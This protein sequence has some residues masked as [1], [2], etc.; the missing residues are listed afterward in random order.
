MKITDLKLKRYSCPYDRP[1]SNAKYTYTHLNLVVTTIET[2]D[3]VSGIG[4][5]EG[6]EIVADTL[7]QLREYV[8]GED[9]FAVERI[10]EKMYLPKIFGRK[11]L[12]TRAISC[13]DIALWDLIGKATG[14]PL[15]KLVGGFRDKVP[16]YI[17]GGYFEGDRGID[18]LVDEMTQ[19]VARGATALKMKIGRVSIRQDVERVRAVREAVGDDILLLVDANNAYKPYEAIQI[20][21]H[22]E[23]LGVY[24]FEEPVAPDDL[25]GSAEVARALDI[26]IAAGENE[27]TRYG[28]R[29][30]IEAEAVDIIN[31]D[32]QILGGITEWRKVAS[33]AAA[34]HIPV[35]PHGHQ[36]IHVHLV[37]GAANG[38]IVEYY[39]ENVNPILTRMFTQ[40]LQLENGAVRPPSG[41]G[42][43]VELKEDALERYRVA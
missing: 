1:I 2:T 20:G 43:G 18:G 42:I 27:Y 5:V 33:L 9:P 7:L 28:F 36:E 13:V 11:G 14:L 25:K 41:P 16:A 30:L 6:N 8:I 21:R 3:G 24:W 31:A 29:D 4:W 15:Y 37:A 22:L 39:R 19:N 40:P 17:A 32:A 12:T 23:T 34:H 38:L 26:P 35:A 10:W